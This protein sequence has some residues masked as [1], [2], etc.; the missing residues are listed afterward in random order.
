MVDDTPAVESLIS[1]LIEA[2]NTNDVK[3]FAGVF[4]EDADFTNVF[5]QP[6]RGRTAVEDFHAP[7]FSEPR[8]PGLPSFVDARLE[9]LNSSIRFLRG[10][11]AAI[12]VM[13]QQTGAIAPDGHAWGTRFGLLNLVVT[14]EKGAWAIA[15]FH[16]MDLPQTPIQ[17]AR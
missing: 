7:F 17:K 4:A 10:D 2:H 6:A 1:R 5:G 16:N 9:V 12:D 15:V 8:Q 3:A 13:W 14:R 11:V